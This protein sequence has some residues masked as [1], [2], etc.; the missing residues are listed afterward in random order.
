MLY[1]MPGLRTASGLDQWSAAVASGQV[2]ST[3]AEALWQRVE[4]MFAENDGVG[5]ALT[6]A[7]LAPAMGQQVTAEQFA[8]GVVDHRPGQAAPP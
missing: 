1:R 3:G 4:Q 2:H 6:G 7:V 8:A 5:S